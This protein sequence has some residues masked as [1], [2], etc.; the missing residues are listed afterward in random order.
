MTIGRP[1]VRYSR[2]SVR[3][4]VGVGVG[5]SVRVLVRVRE[6]VRVRVGVGVGV[7]VRVRVRVRV[8]VGVRVRVRV[9]VA[10]LAVTQH[11]LADDLSEVD[12]PLLCGRLAWLGLASGS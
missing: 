7:G 2:Q 3:A 4:W 10:C 12:P 11:L 1:T 8:R 5:A 9:R 6:R